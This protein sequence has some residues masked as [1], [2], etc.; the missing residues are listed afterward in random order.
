MSLS[1]LIAEGEIAPDF[2]AVDAEGKEITLS[3]LRGRHRAAL[4]FY[5]GDNTPVCT[6]QLCELRDSWA[7]L[8]DL[9]IEVFGINAATSER[10]GAFRARHRFPFP[11]LVDRGGEIASAYGCQGLFGS[12]KRTVYLIDKRGRVAFARRGRPGSAE[13]LRAAENLN[14]SDEG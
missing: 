7:G 1:G 8:S 4:I 3:A 13:L 10:H 5:P 9:D 11:L 6:A 12:V 14:D 2:A